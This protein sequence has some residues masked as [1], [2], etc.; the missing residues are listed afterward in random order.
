MMTPMRSRA[1]F[2][3]GDDPELIDVGDIG[4][5]TPPDRTDGNRCEGYRCLG[6]TKTPAL[7]YFPPGTYKVSSTIKIG[8]HTQLVGD[9]EDWP[10]IKATSNFGANV[11]VDGSPQDADGRRWHGNRA[12][13]HI[14]KAIRYLKIDVTD[15]DAAVNVACLNWA[16]GQGTSL[17]SMAFKMRV[18]SRHL[19]VTMTH[20][21]SGMFM[22]ELVSLLIAL[23]FAAISSDQQQS[24]YGG[25]RALT[26][27]NQRFHFRNLKFHRARTAIQVDGPGVSVFQD[28]E[29]I[30]CGTGIDAREDASFTLLDSTARNVRR[31]ITTRE[32]GKN[33]SGRAGSIVIDNLHAVDVKS[34]MDDD[35]NLNQAIRDGVEGEI[36]LDTWTR[37]TG[38]VSFDSAEDDP[39]DGIEQKTLSSTNG[40]E[41]SSFKPD[42]LLGDGGKYFTRP[43]PSYEDAEV[44]DIVNVKDR[45]ARGDGKADDTHVLN[46]ILL[47]NAENGKITYFPHGIYVVTDTIYI[48]PNSSII[49]EVWS[50]INGM[51]IYSSIT[52]NEY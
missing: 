19:G 35:S 21:G 42:V 34:I 16:V 10:T 24:F 7:V 12:E 45:G 14:H 27:L 5:L 31:V 36:I 8:V 47:E 25:D 48:P 37:G 28:I 17:R 11:V 49:G 30:D 52:F 18:N 43:R 33:E 15:V 50:T 39:E 20:R 38:T 4:F 44:D 41:A 40:H 2:H 9:A 3:V 32:L 29:F 22:G 1:Q 46:E 13:F 23:S 26:V 51:Y 6:S